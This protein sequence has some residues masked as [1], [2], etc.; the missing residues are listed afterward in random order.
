M[1]NDFWLR[2]RSS[3]TLVERF[4][5]RLSCI[6][7]N[8]TIK[9]IL[10]IFLVALHAYVVGSVMPSPHHPP[11][12]CKYT[13]NLKSM[14]LLPI[15]VNLEHHLMD[16]CDLEMWVAA[17]NYSDLPDNFQA[18]FVTWHVLFEHNQFQQ[19]ESIPPSVVRSRIPVQISRQPEFFEIV[20]AQKNNLKYLREKN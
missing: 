3:T 11:A 9:V 8:T 17:K 2:G 19:I 6:I 4:G 10:T 12:R 13:K 20:P 15:A 14:K 1:E 18:L 5:F 7:H 16:S